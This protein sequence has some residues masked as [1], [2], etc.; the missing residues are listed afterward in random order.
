VLEEDANE[1]GDAGG[2]PWSV[3]ENKHEGVDAYGFRNTADTR[4]G[5]WAPYASVPPYATKIKSKHHCI[6]PGEHTT[7][8]APDFTHEPELISAIIQKRDM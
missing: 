7:K 4:R 8:M 5:T 3:V 2:M 1:S 6:Q